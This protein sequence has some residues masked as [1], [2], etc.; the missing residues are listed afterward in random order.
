MFSF[1]EFL[2]SEITNILA[3]YFQKI[4]EFDEYFFLNRDKNQYKVAWTCNRTVNTPIGMATF[5]Q[6]VYWDEINKKHQYPIYEEFGIKKRAR[7]TNDL[8]FS[9]LDNLIENL[10]SKK[11]YFNIQSE[12]KY[13]SFSKNLISRIFKNVKIEKLIPE[14]KHKVL[15]NQKLNICAV[16][17]FVTCWDENGLKQQ[18][19]CRILTFNLG[20]KEIYSYRNKLQK[21]I[22]AF[23]LFKSGNGLNQ[24]QLYNF[25]T[26]TI[27]NHYD[28][29]LNI[30][31][32]QWDY[33]NYNLVVAG[34]GALW[35]KAMATWLGCYYILDK[36]HAYS[37]LWKSF[38]GVKGKKKESHDWTKYIDGTTTFASGDCNQLLSFLK[39]N[40]NEKVYNYFKNNAHGIVNQNADWNICC[41]AESDVYHFL[42][43]LT[44]G[45]KIY[46]YQTLN[47]ML[48]VKAN[49]LNTRSYLNST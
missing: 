44:N 47:N 6:R 21:K 39:P 32:V 46:N 19:C 11:G 2:K 40:V 33:H 29:N 42:K 25:T 38:V 34:D 16:D 10:I 15:D 20:K 36:Y 3:K 14:Q 9:I 45:A 30:L 31:G 13:T 41:C 17:A 37:Y 12:F 18:Y 5:R 24:E 1:K 48:I 8:Y 27:F 7:I 23:L 35:I 49:Y 26:Q 4:H 22:T 28:I 43:S